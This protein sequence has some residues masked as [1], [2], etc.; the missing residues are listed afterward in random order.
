MQIGVRLLPYKSLTG[1]DK[2][3]FF[4]EDCKVS[5]SLDSHY[6]YDSRLKIDKVNMYGAM[7]LAD[8]INNH[9]VHELSDSKRYCELVYSNVCNC[10]P[11]FTDP[12]VEASIERAK[13]ILRIGKMLM[14]KRENEDA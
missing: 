10:D 1:K 9:K 13:E 12:E 11:N 2:Y 4:C 6:L 14:Q 5:P 7:Q 8:A 3:K